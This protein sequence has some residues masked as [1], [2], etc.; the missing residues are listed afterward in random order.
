[1]RPTRSGFDNF[2]I[3][4]QYHLYVNPE[5]QFIFTVGGTAAI[6]GTGSSQVANSFST[7]TPT[8][9]IGKGFGD[10]PDS[11]AWLRPVNF[12]RQRRRRAADPVHHPLYDDIAF[13]R[14]RGHRDGQSERPAVELRAE[15]TLLTTTYYGYIKG[16]SPRRRA[17]PS[18]DVRSFAEDRLA[19]RVGKYFGKI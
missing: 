4:T 2:V 19:D 15:Y 12:T 3:G 1:M 17:H 14:D 13:G 16:G 8:A 5:H 6:G 7:L 9:Y 11:M 10:L 18:H